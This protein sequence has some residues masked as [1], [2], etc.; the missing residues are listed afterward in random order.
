[1]DFLKT[2]KTRMKNIPYSRKYYSIF[3]VFLDCNGLLKK[4]LTTRYPNL[5]TIWNNPNPNRRG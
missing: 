1:M 3:L 5:K 4:I 2:S